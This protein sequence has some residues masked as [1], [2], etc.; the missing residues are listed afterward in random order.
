VSTGADRARARRLAA[1]AALLP[2]L[3]GLAG[4]ATTDTDAG[5]GV[6][7]VTEGT[8]GQ[9]RWALLAE[10][11]PEG[12]RC[13]ALSWNGERL[14]HGCQRDPIKDIRN[15]EFY[16]GSRELAEGQRVYF[17]AVPPSVV[18]VR[19]T[20]ARFVENGK[21]TIVDPGGTRR[22]TKTQS[23]ETIGK[24]GLANRYWIAFAPAG[25]ELPPRTGVVHLDAKG[26]TVRP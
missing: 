9:D 8:R 20:S 26:R 15:P 11:L 17:G 1:T 23:V 19:L 18:E 7:L 5:A 2:A 6:Y 22:I 10:T 21:R 12:N 3:L 14:V 24:S 4:C 13:V 16:G 25:Y